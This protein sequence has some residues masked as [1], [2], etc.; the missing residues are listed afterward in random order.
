MAVGLSAL[1]LWVRLGMDDWLGERPMLVLFFVPIVLS[2][3]AAGLAAGLMA[4]GI[5]ATGAAY[6]VI[7]PR[8]A[9]AFERSVDFAQWLIFLVVGVLMSVMLGERR[10][11][12]IAGDASER[13]ARLHATER[14]VRW[15]F[16][17][18]LCCL[19]GIGVMSYLG[20]NQMGANM[21]A[22][23][24]CHR[25]IHA[26]ND[27]ARHLVEGQSAQRGYTLTGNETYSGIFREA[28]SDAMAALTRL[29]TIV[30]AE[31]GKHSSLL[32]LQAAVERRLALAEA[33]IE[34][35]RGGGLPAAL[36]APE[37]IAG[38]KL[39]EEIIAILHQHIAAEQTLLAS[40]EL[41]SGSHAT[42]TKV[43]L[44]GGGTIAFV[45]V[46]LALFAI[47]RDFAGS[48]AASAALQQAHAQL[49][50][51]VAE[52]TS[53]LEA[54]N[55]A[56][57]E[58]KARL[59]TVTDLA[60]VGLVIVDEGHRYRYANRS[61][62]EILHLPAGDLTG[63]RIADVIPSVYEEAIRPRLDRAF[64]GERVNYELRLPSGDEDR[65]NIYA[66]S[67]E[68]GRDKSG[69]I[70][71]VVIVDITERKL[72]EE[73]LRASMQEISELRVALN[74]HAIVAVTDAAGN[75]T[76]VNDQF[77]K[78]SGYAREELLGKN[79][80]I[81]NSG[82]HGREFFT[83]MWSTISG[84]TAWHGDIRNRAKDGS[85]YWV[86]TTIVPF[87]DK[88]GRARRYMA[89]R[90]DITER[91]AAEEHR[92]RQ[93]RRVAMLAE[94][95]RRLV[96]SDSPE[97]LIGGIFSAVAEELGVEMFFNYMVSEDG[98]RLVMRESGGLSPALTEVFRELRV[99]DGLCG[100]IAANQEPLTLNHLQDSTWPPAA[101]GRK[102][103]FQAYAGFP[104]IAA[105]RLI[106]TLAFATLKRPEFQNEELQIMRAVSDQVATAV[107]RT[108]LHREL[109]ASEGRFREMTQSL[110]LLAWTGRADGTLD[111]LSQQWAEY[112]GREVSEEL[113]RNWAELIHPDDREHV[114]AQWQEVFRTGEQ[115]NADYRIRRSDG[116]YRWFKGRAVPF[117]DEEGRIR[118]WFGSNMDIEDLI[119]AED[120]LRDRE[121]RL[122]LVLNQLD[123]IVWTTDSHLRISSIGGQGLR[124]AGSE[125]EELM[126]RDLFEVVPGSDEA[127]PM[128]ISHRAALAGFGSSYEIVFGGRDLRASVAPFRDAAGMVTGVIGLAMDVTEQK[129]AEA[130]MREE[131]IFN[132]EVLDSLTA[133]IAVLDRKG[134]LLIVNAAWRGHASEHGVDRDTSGVGAN[135]LKVCDRAFREQGDELAGKVA[136]GIR[137][138]IEGR[139]KYFGLEYP[140]HSPEQTRWFQLHVCPVT[141]GH[142]AVVTA[143]EDITSRKQAEEAVQSMNQQLE[144]RV[145]QR[146]KE[147]EAS[148]KELE[149][150][151]YSVSHDLRAPLRAVDGFSQAV[152]E[153]F[154]PSLP[155]EGQRYLAT[156]RSGAQR[157]GALIDDL[158]TFSRLSR[159]D[160]N[161]R[162]VDT[163]A[164]VQ[165]TLVELDYLR[166]GRKVEVTLHPLPPSE[167][168]PA[169][170]RQVWSNLLSNALKYTRK[171]ETAFIEV[172]WN[173]EGREG[174]YVKDNGSGFD[175]RYAHK[176][177]GVFQRLHRAEDF[178][179]TGVGLAIVQRIVHRH[180]GEVWA[181]AEVDRGAT[182]CFNLTGVPNY[183]Q[184]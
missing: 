89:I 119:H 31:P 68:P 21:A 30:A 182:F 75:I 48:R 6:W 113:R 155:P 148:N 78:I 172:G 158:L 10:Q 76:E 180:G 161:K 183:E 17:F 71:V 72:A 85:Y 135:Y 132:R 110:P 173:T 39:Q 83:K 36:A 165:A 92:E 142:R 100:W 130:A 177:F 1:T 120:T 79:H 52:R 145:A 117:R 24:K 90:F 88:S 23:V 141:A 143:H 146:T 111:F 109:A 32:A 166:E 129:R 54:A 134:R 123:A 181:H 45:F 12:R 94:I 102:I 28:A 97:Q 19:G 2:A 99:G 55:L 175:M 73:Q 57:T 126:G 104:L 118:K 128:V 136:D 106:G 91:K 114:L 44:L 163:A 103:G 96:L 60:R 66:V 49:E 144:L 164:L 20:V 27:L 81:L 151:S 115:L 46:A 33:V 133:H 4:T 156:I 50:S 167:G 159:A 112:T 174:F 116:T 162:T 101:D 63:R 37:T 150:F 70:V 125:P 178:E 3:Y 38:Y 9:L 14:K 41:D 22:V 51:R 169:L 80:R 16:G 82:F 69:S 154:G 179:G 18:A 11:A 137:A 168:D 152:L 153:D 139:L 131:E 138:V 157:M 40:L 42:S 93:R 149:S 147:L 67:Y 84:G 56:L 5:T 87:R 176:L 77:C 62:S 58:N 25:E 64:S 13:G 184:H 107:E 15:S 108:R 98:T 59:R 86:A 29:N 74:E 8:G 53:E 95:S 160:L 43:A 127:T 122:Q 170:L 7:F 47:G 35:R 61:Y 34:A 140:C 105:G 171:C 26:M 121:Q 65:E 124:A